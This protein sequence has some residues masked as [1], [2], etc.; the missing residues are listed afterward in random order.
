MVGRDTKVLEVAEIDLYSV[1]LREFGND[2][3]DDPWNAGYVRGRT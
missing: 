3:E 1:I 2:G